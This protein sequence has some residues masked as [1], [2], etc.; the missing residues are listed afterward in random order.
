MLVKGI[1]SSIDTDANTIDVILPEYN[2]VVVRPLKIYRE[3]IIN[4]LKVNDF[5]V[6]AVFND[7]F[8]DC[9]IL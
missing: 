3:E 9:I 2:N 5:V 1:V 7:D 8:N 6:V 4:T